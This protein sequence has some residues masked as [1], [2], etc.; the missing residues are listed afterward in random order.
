MEIREISCEKRTPDWTSS[1][2]STAKF[3][4]AI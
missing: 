3:S 4:L 2:I 1:K